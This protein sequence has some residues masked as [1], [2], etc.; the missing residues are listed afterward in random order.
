MALHLA[1]PGLAGSR[2]SAVSFPPLVMVGILSVCLVVAGIPPF[3]TVFVQE[4]L[5]SHFY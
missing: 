4:P 3:V 5:L 1:L 2:A